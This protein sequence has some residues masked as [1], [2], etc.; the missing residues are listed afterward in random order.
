MKTNLN[1]LFSRQKFSFIGLPP[2]KTI[3]AFQHLVSSGIPIRFHRTISPDEHGNR[4]KLANFG[5]LLASSDV[6]NTFG[7]STVSVGKSKSTSKSMI[8]ALMK[9]RYST[10]VDCSY[11]EK[12]TSQLRRMLKNC[13]SRNHIQCELLSGRKSF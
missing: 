11:K 8:L 5:S 12:V 3:R 4:L 6:S 9:K 1:P 10:F 2:F 13:Q 7:W